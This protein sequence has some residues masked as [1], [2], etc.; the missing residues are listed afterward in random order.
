MKT[1]VLRA[2]SE[3][4]YNKGGP[5][6]VGY[7]GIP[8]VATSERRPPVSLGRSA[9]ALFQAKRGAYH[10]LVLSHIRPGSVKAS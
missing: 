7:L 4:D 9:I 5:S 6:G 1:L 8:Q 3:R 2:R 10:V